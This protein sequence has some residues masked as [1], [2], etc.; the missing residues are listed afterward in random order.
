MAAD[1][2]PRWSTEILISI[3]FAVTPAGER[4][5]WVVTSASRYADEEGTTELYSKDELRAFAIE[6]LEEYGITQHD[7]NQMKS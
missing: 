3:C 4:A 2:F 1:S 6:Q 5:D 7:V